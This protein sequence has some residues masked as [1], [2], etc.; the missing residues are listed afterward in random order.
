MIYKVQAYDNDLRKWVDIVGH[1]VYDTY[2][3]AIR[4]T[5]IFKRRHP[6]LR[7]RLRKVRNGKD[8]PHVD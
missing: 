6:R 4:N 5:S 1:P 7:V 8:I 2:D 3:E